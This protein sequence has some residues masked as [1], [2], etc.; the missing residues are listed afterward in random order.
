MKTI[1]LTILS[2]CAFSSFAQNDSILPNLNGEYDMELMTIDGSMNF[3]FT[4]E[5]ISIVDD[6]PGD[7]TLSVIH[8]SDTIAYIALDGD[9]VYIK[10]S[11]NPY[12]TYYVGD[13]FSPDFGAGFELL[14]DFSLNVGDTAYYQYGPTQP[15]TVLSI[16]ILNVQGEP[17]RKLNLHNGESWIQGMGSTYHPLG[18]K[19][20]YFEN[21]YEVCSADMEYLGTSPVDT[22]SYLGPCGIP[23]TAELINLETGG[24]SIYP[25]PTTN[26]LNISTEASSN[27]VVVQLFDELGREII[28]Q[29]GNGETMQ[30]SLTTLNTGI[31]IYQV[32]LDDG[33][34]IVGRVIKE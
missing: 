26:D 33:S 32:A 20:F 23:S 24:L 25:N 34:T 2:L 28:K 18:P 30:L 3:V 1:F 6:S 15:I 10:R 9:Q 16:D 4:P 11:G 31:Y 13:G 8:N 27:I 7:D 5:H 14:Y 12:T 19:L 22:S 21:A 17:R 29:D